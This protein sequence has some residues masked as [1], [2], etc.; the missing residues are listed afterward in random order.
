MSVKTLVAISIFG[1]TVASAAYAGERCYTGNAYVGT[2]GGDQVAAGCGSPPNT[3]GVT[4]TVSGIP[5]GNV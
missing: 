1:A 2:M 3:A 4:Y 5:F